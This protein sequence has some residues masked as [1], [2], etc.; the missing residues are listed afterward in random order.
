MPPYIHSH[1]LIH[2]SAEEITAV[3]KILEIREDWHAGQIDTGKCKN[4]IMFTWPKAGEID[5]CVEKKVTHII[6]IINS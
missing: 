2:R 5:V 4:K 6:G 3:G 1:T